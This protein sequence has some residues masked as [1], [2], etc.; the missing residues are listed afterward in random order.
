MAIMH[1]QGLEQEALRVK[2]DRESERLFGGRLRY[3]T[4][5]YQHRGLLDY[6][7]RRDLEMWWPQ[8][9]ERIAGTLEALA[10]SL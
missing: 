6:A 3:L 1:R 7:A 5:Q 2:E 4:S 9:K 8:S 10:R